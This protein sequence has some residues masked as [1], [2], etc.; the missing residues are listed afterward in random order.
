MDQKL[1]ESALAEFDYLNKVMIESCAQVAFN[2]IIFENALTDEVLTEAEDEAK[3]DDKEAKVKT[4]Y[5]GKAKNTAFKMLEGLKKFAQTIWAKIKVAINETIAKMANGKAFKMIESYNKK[6]DGKVAYI[7]AGK[8]LQIDDPKSVF[9]VDKLLT[10]FADRQDE[11]KAA[12]AIANEI[13]LPSNFA[14]ATNDLKKVKTLNDVS[15]IFTSLCSYADED[16]KAQTIEDY[17]NKM[18][19]VV[20]YKD[21]ASEIKGEYDKGVKATKDEI[22]KYSNI[23]KQWNEENNPSG[24][25]A[26]KKS[27][28]IYTKLLGTVHS[29]FIGYLKWVIAASAQ[30]AK[31]V[32]SASKGGVV[33][34]KNESF[35]G[36]N[37]L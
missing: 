33:V 6:S 10:N 26:T 20:N 28:K 29:G 24:A 23:I 37:L 1:F 36:L 3:K 11:E 32:N 35:M 25:D 13:K 17:L 16:T 21:V 12:E 15:K 19:N 14:K 5:V 34:A 22:A 7:V 31:A 9:I 27:M 8:N 30:I 18:K 4:D 2:S